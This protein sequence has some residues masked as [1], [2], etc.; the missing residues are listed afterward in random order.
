MKMTK[1]WCIW[2]EM[3]QMPKHGY[4]W[5]HPE[6]FES[7]YSVSQNLKMVEKYLRGEIP[8][9]TKNG[10]KLGRDTVEQF[11]VDMYDFDRRMR[12]ISKLFKA[13]KEG[14]PITEDVFEPPRQDCFK[15]KT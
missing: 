3:G 10:N 14:A 5:I 8:R 11:L 15:S 9:I 2:C 12:N 1:A 6:C 7:M 4:Y 13:Y